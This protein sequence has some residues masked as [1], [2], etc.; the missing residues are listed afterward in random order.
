MKSFW[1]YYP[2]IFVIFGVALKIQET[3][4]LAGYLFGIVFISFTVLFWV[5]MNVKDNPND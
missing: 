2:I 5:W 3:S 1:W 4:F